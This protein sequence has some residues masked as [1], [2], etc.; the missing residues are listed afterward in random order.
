[1]RR[2]S[3][4][5]VNSLMV[6]AASRI[7]FYSDSVVITTF[8]STAA[9]TYFALAAN[10]VEYVRRFIKSMTNVFIPAISG[11]KAANQKEKLG[12]LL[13]V[14]T[15]YTLLL[16]V[17]IGV[18]LLAYRREFFALWMGPEFG[19][20]SGEVLL[21]LLAP[22][23]LAMGMYNF[24]AMLYGIAKHRAL[25]MMSLAEALLNLLLS[26]V[27]VKKFG[28]AGVALGTAI[29][30]VLNYVVWLPRYACRLLGVSYFDFMRKAVL[31]P[32]LTAIPL[33]LAII[34]AKT[35]HPADN[36]PGFLAQLAFCCGIFVAVIWRAFLREDIK[37]YAASRNGSF[38]GLRLQTK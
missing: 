3:T 23:I 38:F 22:Q 25:A 21:I 31:P 29:P 5:G 18:T 15:R 16:T 7:I 20:R 24:S 13:Y 34:I 14:G 11:L 17:G 28:L 6:I 36:W 8:M 2:I 19:T 1:M 35:V 37:Q 10:L 9:V 30:Q 27:L 4:Y 26:I 33:L 32:L 12:E